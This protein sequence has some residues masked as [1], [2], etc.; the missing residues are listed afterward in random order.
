MNFALPSATGILRVGL[1]SDTHGFIDPAVSTLFHGVDL[2]L[3]A[4][5]IGPRKIRTS[6]EQLAPLIAVL[7]NNDFDADLRETE[8]LKIGPWKV[9]VQHIVDPSNPLPDLARK[10]ERAEPH[11]VVFGHTHRTYDA[12]H[13]QIRFINPGYSGRKRFEELRSIA[14]LECSTLALN[15]SVHSLPNPP[16]P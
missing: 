7:G 11:L 2:I 14:L 1:I 16:K 6:L 5:D 15:L 9:L 4:G 13:N 12:T 10:L 3:H 8:T